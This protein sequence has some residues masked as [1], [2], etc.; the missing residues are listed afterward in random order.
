MFLTCSFSNA[1]KSLDLTTH[2]D[3]TETAFAIA[4]DIVLADGEV[5]EE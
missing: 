4:T 5:T 1:T 2:N 3:L